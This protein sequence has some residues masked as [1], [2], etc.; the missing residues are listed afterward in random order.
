MGS[1][2]GWLYSNDGDKNSQ[3]G[4]VEFPGNET[5]NSVRQLDL[6]LE[7]SEP[8]GLYYDADLL[9]SKP[10]R[11]NKNYIHFSTVIGR[12]FN[13]E[14]FQCEYLLRNSW[15]TNCKLYPKH[16]Q[17]NCKDGN[18][19]IPRVDILKSMGGVYTFKPK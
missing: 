19:W 2:G 15:G 13:V 16:Y 7:S 1:R 17:L 8:V 9:E 3:K 6:K 10:G 4:Y 5:W 11:L 18:L 12:R 14:T